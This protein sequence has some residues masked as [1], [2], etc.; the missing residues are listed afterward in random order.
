[1]P[2]LSSFRS[3][4][5]RQEELKDII[6]TKIP[7]NS[8]AIAHARS[9]GDLRE[10]FEYKAAKQMQAVLNKFRTDLERDLN[11]AQGTDFSG[12]DASGVNIGTVVTLEK[13]DGGEVEYTVLG[14]WDSDP[15]TN[16]VSYLSDIGQ[17][18]I[19]EKP[20]ARVEIRDLES[21][22]LHTLTVKSIRPWK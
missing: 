15:E 14:A 18:L 2:T 4:E 19:G 12:A 9:Y 11:I 20:G 7:E 22:E 10:N 21:E 8:A 1:M 17:A 3:F 6:N 5:E 16:L 13:A